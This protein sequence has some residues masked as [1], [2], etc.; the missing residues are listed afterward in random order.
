MPPSSLLCRKIRKNNLGI[1]SIIYIY[2]FL[3]ISKENYPA[4]F[5]S[6]TYVNIKFFCGKEDLR[7]FFIL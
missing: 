6:D 7:D 3:N 1:M 4:N 5:Y 2:V